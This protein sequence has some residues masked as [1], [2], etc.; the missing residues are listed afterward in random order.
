MSKSQNRAQ[1]TSVELD[2]L[3]AVRE[4]ARRRAFVLLG[5][6]YRK[7]EDRRNWTIDVKDEHGV[8][9]LSLSLSA[10]TQA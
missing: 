7:G 8:V 6:G 1:R 9:V 10:A 5:E 3:D 4:E 2:G